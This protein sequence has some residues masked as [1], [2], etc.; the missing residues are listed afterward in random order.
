MRTGVGSA[1]EQNCQ[2]TVYTEEVHR[3]VLY[4]VSNKPTFWFD[5]TTNL[6]KRNFEFIQKKNK[7]INFPFN[8]C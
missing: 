6:L 8:L 2:F 1:H 4:F 7:T 3:G 5:K